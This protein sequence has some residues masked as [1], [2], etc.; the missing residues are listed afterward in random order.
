MTFE[1]Y[2]MGFRAAVPVQRYHDLRAGI[3]DTWEIVVLYQDMLEAE[4]LPQTHIEGAHYLLAMRLCRLPGGL[5][6]YQ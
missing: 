3:L 2:V 1:N 5:T 6:T 4:C